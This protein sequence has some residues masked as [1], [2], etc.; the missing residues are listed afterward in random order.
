MG[1]EK[2]AAIA[3]ATFGA[4]LFGSWTLRMYGVTDPWRPYAIAVQEYMAAGVRGDSIALTR[5]SANL[6]P[7]A[8][9]LDAAHRQPRM[10]SAWAHQL[11]TNAGQRRGDTVLVALWADTVEGCSNFNTVSATLLNHSAAPRLLAVSSPCITPPPRPDSLVRLYHDSNS[12]VPHSVR[13]VVK[14]SA[15]WIETWPFIRGYGLAKLPSVDFVKQVVVIVALGSRGGTGYDI[16][17]DSTAVTPAQQLLFVR[18]TD[19]DLCPSGAMLTQPLDVVRVPR[20]DLPIRFVE[21]T[22]QVKC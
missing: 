19:N 12:Q 21:D 7:V 20:T 8:W 15:R 11:M 2:L 14:D 10:V 5:R 18:I 17:V 4:V 6:E 3:V 13:E 9:V 22:V 16:T 1:R